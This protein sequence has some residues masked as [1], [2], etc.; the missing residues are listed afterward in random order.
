MSMF[1]IVHS[2]YIKHIQYSY[3]VHAPATAIYDIKNEM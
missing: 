3:T 1:E 2:S